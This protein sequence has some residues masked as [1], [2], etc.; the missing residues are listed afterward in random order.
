MAR[1]TKEEAQETRNRLLDT[2]EIV[3]NERGVSRTS[4]AEIAEAAGVTRGAIY[5]HFKNKLDLFNAMME[6]VIL[7]VEEVTEEFADGQ[8]ADPVCNIRDR[9]VAILKD[10]GRNPQMQRVFDIMSHKCEYV[11]D[12]APLKDRHLEG[13]GRC[14]QHV[15]EGF[16]QAIRK[17]R[18]P[19]GTDARLAAVGLHALIDGLI[20]NWLLDPKYFSFE[21]DA[22]RMVD[23]YLHGLGV[24]AAAPVK[25]KGAPAK[26]AKAAT[27]ASPAKAPRKKSA[28]AG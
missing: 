17:G 27:P 19:K 26:P 25:G 9:S 21:R 1:K 18:L 8:I 13:R 23:T 22:E 11:D 3:F 7:P 15:E 10:L 5:W 28:M 12:M 24:C 4:L 2:A 6:R 14:V 20:M 16:R